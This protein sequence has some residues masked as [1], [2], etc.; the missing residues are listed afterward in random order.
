MYL[1]LYNELQNVGYNC[2]KLHEI[3]SYLAEHCS[4]YKTNVPSIHWRIHKY[5]MYI[6]CT[7]FHATTDKRDRGRV[8][9]YGNIADNQL[10]YRAKF[11][12]M[13]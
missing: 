1:K 7:S 11:V 10:N 8:R 5:T 9:E 4:R 3:T 12:I 2:T 6:S 13:N